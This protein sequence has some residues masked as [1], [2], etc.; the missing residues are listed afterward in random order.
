[1]TTNPTLAD[2]DARRS[3]ETE[4][5][6][7]FLVEAAAGT[8][9][10]TSLVRRMVALLREGQT[11]PDR[12]AAVTFTRKAGAHLREMFQLG[13]EEA[14]RRE[15]DRKRQERLAI[16]L[17][18]LDRCF[19]GTIHSFCA[20]LLRERPL[21]G[22]VD[23]G[24]KELDEIEDRAIRE[25]FWGTYVQQKFVEDSALLHQLSDLG[26]GL[27]DL[28]TTYELISGYPDVTITAT[29]VSKPDLNDVRL[30]VK[31][32]LSLV[33]R[34]LPRTVPDKGWDEFQNHLR[35]A[36]RLRRIL[37]LD[38]DSDFVRLLESL[39]HEGRLTQNRWPDKSQAKELKNGFDQ[40]RE[41][42]IRPALHRW[43]EYVHPILLNTILPAAKNLHGR[44]LAT[45]QLN[46]QDLLILA[47]DLLRH[48]P[49]VRQNLQER[50]THL[51]V[52][53]FQDTDPIQAEVMLYLTSEASNGADWRRL[54][55]RPGALFV[56]GDPKQSIYRFRRADIVTYDRMK[57]I[58]EHGGGRV[59]ELTTNFRSVNKIC[60]WTN[61]VFR[62]IFPISG[63]REQAA[64]SFLSGFRPAGD[65]WCGVFK[66]ETASHGKRGADL[67]AQENAAKIAR[68][69][70]WAIDTGLPVLGENGAEETHSQAAEPG[71]FMIILR[72]R[73]RLH[74]YA[75]ALE[76]EGIPYDISGSKAF[77][78]SEELALLLP[79]LRAVSDPDD[80]VALV[81]FLRGKLWGVNDNALYQFRR[82]GGRFSYLTDCPETADGRIAEAFELLR[83]ARA[84][85]HHLPPG[86]ALGR[87][88]ERLGI[89]AHGAAQELGD[90]RSGSILKA[91]TLTR[92]LSAQ[93]RSFRNI[94]DRLSRLMEDEDVEGM[95]A[96]PGRMNAVRLMN[97][98]RAKGLEAPIVFLA[99]PCNF[100]R[101]PPLF[102][103][104][105]D[106]AQ[107]EGHFLIATAEG[108]QRRELARPQDWNHKVSEE[109]AFQAA[110][111]DRVLY[112]A[113]T[114]ARNMLVVSVHRREV[115][116]DGTSRSEGPWTK[117]SRSLEDEL[118]SAKSLFG[119]APR[120][121]HQE[122]PSKLTDVRVQ[123][124]EKHGAVTRPT[125]A[126][127]QV[128]RIVHEKDD[129]YAAHE[130][131]GRGVAWGRL[132]H[133]LLESLM[134]SQVSDVA[135]YIEFLLKA[136]G[137][138]LDE[139][140]EIVR[141]IESVRASELW[142]RACRAKRR[143]VEVP[144]ALMV[145]SREMGIS[146]GPEK[147]V[148][149][150][151]IDLVFYDHEEW[152]IVDYKSDP[153]RDGLPNLISIYV[154]Q[155]S[156]Y[157]RYWEQ[158]TGEATKAALFF[159]ETGE[160]KWID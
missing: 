124:K 105:R 84:L 109:I 74:H 48:H 147:A 95:S 47:R 141:I 30:D 120:A 146:E 35:R 41:D 127:T 119:R 151:V 40:L 106:G 3:I 42:T 154:P 5:E 77:G 33:Q 72:N 100:S 133:R 8:G 121:A 59:L 134:R 17:N 114:R 92:C 6:T 153:V 13:L 4:L 78:E 123:I 20:R 158:L 156:Q 103:I 136:E 43:R 9:K 28:R 26:I 11:Q 80:P 14:H 99:D 98:H 87:I 157:R 39:D 117:L 128:T 52:D 60:E 142:Q 111:E 62:E 118:P 68:W 159:V 89:V 91:Q 64:N 46:F 10:T 70:R 116:R 45:G 132:L 143:L 152:I 36:L 131:H 25:E 23:P 7:T 76:R 115:K 160:I 18:E 19:I 66:L 112:V 29:P 2:Q 53:E 81:S 79:F 83:E 137:L 61:E 56:V 24:F 16:A 104:N 139:A 140:D 96:D 73:S 44:R 15:P 63:T 55:P 31:R 108:F 101:L 130:G 67:I 126:V 51:L 85:A 97:L 82:A 86:A 50:F 12:L 37:D 34:E 94:I 65:A 22:G 58:I 138:P 27:N 144:F 90:S 150:G 75:M 38:V 32:F 149:K 148:L 93:G 1:M 21:E 122:W 113:A 102:S 57:E 125:Y 129:P 88:C 69:I 135:G 49:R 107:A 110:E 54:R 155:I 145:P 71:D